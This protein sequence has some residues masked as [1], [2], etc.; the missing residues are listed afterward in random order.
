[1]REVGYKFF[2]TAVTYL[3]AYLLK[4]ISLNQEESICFRSHPISP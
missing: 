2:S 3:K 4:E 1:M